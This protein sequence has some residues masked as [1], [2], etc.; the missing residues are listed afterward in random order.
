MSFAATSARLRVLGAPYDL[1]SRKG[2]SFRPVHAVTCEHRNVVVYFKIPRNNV[3]AEVRSEGPETRT[4]THTQILRT[5]PIFV[6]RRGADT[7]VTAPS[8][9]PTV[10]VQK[11]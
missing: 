2:H 11:G 1:A 5:K 3:E 6:D 7:A 8:Y 4:H 10:R 9:S